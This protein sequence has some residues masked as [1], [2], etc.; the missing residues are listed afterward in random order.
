MQHPHRA[1]GEGSPTGLDLPRPVAQRSHRTVGRATLLPR[2]GSALFPHSTDHCGCVPLVGGVSST[3]PRRMAP[4]RGHCG[5]GRQPDGTPQTASRGCSN[6]ARARPRT[7][8]CNVAVSS[9]CCSFAASSL[10]A[11][12]RRHA[13]Y[14][15]RV[16]TAVARPL[17]LW[18]C[19]CCG[20]CACSP[21]IQAT[22]RPWRLQR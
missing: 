15:R 4:R 18:P 8:A 14:G 21:F 2:R 17:F 7:R 3:I 13:R 19:R 5:S 20:G 6:G 12:T 16:G 10:F 9:L 22:R 1:T 11:F